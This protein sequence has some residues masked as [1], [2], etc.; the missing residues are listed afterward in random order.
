MTAEKI[1]IAWKEFWQTLGIRHLG[2][3]PN[4]FIPTPKDRCEYGFTNGYDY[5]YRAGEA[6]GRISAYEI[7][8]AIVF[9]E[10]ELAKKYQGKESDKAIHLKNIVHSIREAQ[11]SDMEKHEPQPPDNDE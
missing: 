6:E 9:H 8:I 3:S 5:G 11:A 4:D 7:A 10:Y 1:H 2:L